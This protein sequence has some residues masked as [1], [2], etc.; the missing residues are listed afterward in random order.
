[1]T[2]R[3][4]TKGQKNNGL[5]SSTHKTKDRATRTVLSTTPYVTAV[6]LLV[7]RVSGYQRVIGK[8][9]K[10]QKTQWP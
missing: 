1:M 9:E 7:R 6:L 4:S 3:K 5:Q 10:G 2:K 8:F